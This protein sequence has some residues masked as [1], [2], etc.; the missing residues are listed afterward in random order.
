MAMFKVLSYLRPFWG[1]IVIILV[2]L[3]F[4]AFSQLYLPT[5]MADIVDNGIINGDTTLIMRVGGIMLLVALAGGVSTILANF[6]SSRVA[7]G[8][9][10]A[11]RSAIFSRIQAFSLQEYDQFGAASLITR[12][13]NDVLH[14]QRVVMMS[15]RMMV[16][17]PLMMIGGIIMA[18]SQD[19][20]LSKII[21]YVIPVLVVGIVVLATKAMPLFR[22]LQ[23]KLDKL[24]LVLQENLTGIRVI[25]AFN[26]V[27]HEQKRFDDANK[28]LTS[29]A[30][31]VNKL[32]AV[33]MPGMM[34]LLN[35]TS[36]AVI[37]Y[38]SLRIDAG[39]L[40]IG[41]LMAFLQ[42]IMQ[43]MFSLMMLSMMFIML[44]R[45][46]AS[47]TRM[48]AVLNTMPE[49]KDP[50]V[51]KKPEQKGYVEFRDVTF[52]Y[53]G[54]EYPALNNISFSAAPG[55]VTAILGGTG[56]GKSTLV[57][58]IP[59]F[60]DVDSGSILVD[61]V[62]TRE[63]S[64]ESL[65]Q[66]IGYVPQQAL[67]F[68]GTVAENIRYGK[69]QA[70]DDEV[71]QAAEIAQALEF[72]QNL[73]QGFESEVSQGGSNLS[74]GQKQRLAIARALVRHPEIYIF[75][76]SFSALDF[77]TE[78]RLRDALRQ[79][80]AAAT[81]LIVA[82]RVT[83]VMDADRI[84]VLDQGAVAGIGTHTELMENCDVYREIVLSQ[85][86]EEEIA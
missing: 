49:I 75:D 36:V 10:K 41:S 68:T 30:I 72:I 20:E 14:V 7:M 80:T 2:L 78:S 51:S 74:G 24:N 63:L 22:A 57:N 76:D 32:M 52:S 27:N 64:Q 54:A 42:Y 56:S 43:I 70:S 13:T 8:Y 18:L 46:A 79:H 28:D 9:G 33:G 23:G 50:R 3:L 48:N 55:E 69:S 6:F 15:L 71:R 34:L 82:Q 25:R 19:V 39:S 47:V 35:F 61:G 83:T 4:Q 60:Y 84:I 26:R 86:A 77:K 21:L 66:K 11:L 40:N 85:V 73:A 45:A 12:T 1:A 38:G 59:R 65:R 16:T 31:L 29:T 58:L 81:M 62:D 53:P 5:L 44:P 17:A 37:W 67:V